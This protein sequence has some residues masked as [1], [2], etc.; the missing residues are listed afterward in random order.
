MHQTDR[1]LSKCYSK[2]VGSHTVYKYI[3]KIRKRRLALVSLVAV[4]P[5]L[6]K[7][8]GSSFSPVKYRNSLKN[9]LAKASF[10]KRAEKWGTKKGRKRRRPLSLSF[11]LLPFC[12]S[13]HLIS[14]SGEVSWS[15][16]PAG[17]PLA[18]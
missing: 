15:S 6:K 12:H 7:E 16:E 18:S 3:S 10:P 17:G 14:S 2:V 1:R 13:L 4:H 5:F 9:G 11:S 8:K